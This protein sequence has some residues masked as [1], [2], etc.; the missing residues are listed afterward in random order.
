MS[1]ALLLIV[2]A[3]IFLCGIITGGVFITIGIKLERDK[4]N[5]D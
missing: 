2:G 3:S 5:A 4:T 1:S